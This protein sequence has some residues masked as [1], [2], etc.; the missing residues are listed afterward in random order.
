MLPVG[1]LAAC[2][3]QPIPPSPVH[4][5]Q[6]AAPVAAPIPQPVQQ[7]GLPPPPRPVPKQETY[8]VTVFKVPVQSLLFALARDARLNL[9]VHGDVR[10]EVTL[11]AINQTLP[12]ILSRIGKQVDMRYELDGPNLAVLPDTP[13]LKNYRIDYVNIARTSRSDVSIATQVASTGAAGVINS[14]GGGAG[15]TNNSTTQVSNISNN[16]FWDTLVQNIR[17][18]LAEADRSV[19]EAGA[20]TESS[21]AAGATASAATAAGGGTAP[22]SRSSSRAAVTVIANPETGL[23]AVRATSRQH[24][25]VQE[26]LDLVMASAKRQVLIEATV[27]EVQLSDQYQQGINWA[28]L[29]RGATGFSLLQQPVGGPLSS[30]VAPGI[31]Q[32]LFIGNYANAGSGLGDISATIQLLESFGKVKVLSSPKISVLNNQ[33][34]VLK[35]VDNR[36]YF[37]LTATTSAPQVGVPSITTYT[38]ELHTVPVGFVMSVTPQIADSG[39]VTI[40]VRPTI[41]RIIGYVQDPNPA[42]AAAVVP[43]VSNVPVVQTR[44]MESILKVSSGQVAVMGGLMQDSVNNLKD[45]VPGINRLPVIGDALS[46]R[47]ETATKSELVIFMRPVVVRE[48]SLNGDYKEFRSLLPDNQSLNVHPYTEPERRTPQTKAVGS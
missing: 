3:T 44:E 10:G 4:I 37:L 25:R 43:V 42:L 35:V 46:S 34:A 7:A 6:P 47:N 19:P 18:T 24:E 17:D 27:V 41:S 29:R 31:S 11:N 1:L 16:Q 23:I 38:S 30:G 14:A 36:V 45:S 26:F 40:N 32:G 33:T 39:E 8:S 22:A 48:A 13:Y 12:Q 28:G 5:Q 20:A 21:P 9:D 15:G 2:G